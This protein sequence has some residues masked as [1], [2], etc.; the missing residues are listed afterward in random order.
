MKVDLNK[1]DTE[2]FVV[3]SGTVAGETVYLIFPKGMPSW[4]N[5][6]LIFRSSVWNESGELISAGF[7]KFGN[8][9]EKPEVFGNP[10]TLDG[11]AITEKLDG[12][13]LIL[14]RYKGE[15]MARTRG[16][17]DATKLPNGSEIKALKRKYPKVFNHGGDTWDYSLLFEW[18]SPTNRIVIKHNMLDMKLIGGINHN[19]YSMMNQNQLDSIAKRLG[20]ERPKY[21][22]ADSIDDLVNNVKKFKDSEGV[23][24]MTKD[25]K[26]F[27]IKGE[28]YLMKHRLKDRLSSFNHVLNFYLEKEAKS[29]SDFYKIVEKE[30]DW[31]TAEET[32]ED[33]IKIQNGLQEVEK[34]LNDIKHFTERYKDVPRKDAAIAIN[35]KYQKY[36]LSKIAFNFLNNRLIGD[37]IKKDLLDKVLSDIYL[38]DKINEYSINT[39]KK[40]NNLIKETEH[41]FNFQKT[42]NID[43]KY[44]GATPPSSKSKTFKTIDLYKTDPKMKGVLDNKMV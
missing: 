20:V 27:K 16:T 14:S 3:R 12:S 44:G 39:F 18:L 13:L 38:K 6:T 30:I 42:D 24:L 8:L 41:K 10:E 15:T 17:L 36:G 21:F 40:I 35:D 2:Q 32:K 9:G 29:A 34:I 4:S 7:P 37:D 26:I 11:A 22:E 25:G 19:N 31:E 28:E 33:T 23:C 1:I 43:G 5:D